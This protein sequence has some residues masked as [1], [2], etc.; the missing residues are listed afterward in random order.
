MWHSSDGMTWRNIGNVVSGSED[1]LLS[2]MGGALV[3]DGVG[4]FDFWTS[5]GGSELPMAATFRRHRRNRTAVRTP[6]RDRSAS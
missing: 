3:T 4:R 2:W 1:P 6:A 5:Q